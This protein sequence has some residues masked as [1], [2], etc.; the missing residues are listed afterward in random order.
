[1][2]MLILC[3]LLCGETVVAIQQ[4]TCDQRC[5]ELL[6]IQM[7]FRSNPFLFVCSPARI[8]LFENFTVAYVD[9]RICHASGLF[10]KK[11]QFW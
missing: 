11:L 6:F 1:M 9:V 3:S 5:D 2:R 10:I 7:K 8:S 4:A